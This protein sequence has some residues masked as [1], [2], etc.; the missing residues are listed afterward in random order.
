MLLE[1]ISSHNE[2]RMWCSQQ[3]RAVG[4]QRS[5]ASLRLLLLHQVWWTGLRALSNVCTLEA[6]YA[7]LHIPVL[8]FQENKLNFSHP[9]VWRCLQFENCYVASNPFDLFGISFIKAKPFSVRKIQNHFT[10]ENIS[11]YPSP[12][13]KEQVSFVQWTQWTVF[14]LR[15]IHLPDP[16]VHL[17][18]F[19]NGRRLLH[20]FLFR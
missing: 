18:F 16:K 11:F 8:I 5:F 12:T 14:P 7:K 15:K 6:G 13:L 3:D 20:R 1:V 4:K 10:E 19:F 9:Q 17:F 2:L